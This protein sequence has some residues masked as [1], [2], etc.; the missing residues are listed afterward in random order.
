VAGIR[1]WAGRTVVVTG[2]LGFIGSHFVAELAARGA[3]VICLHRSRNVEMIRAL[4]ETD[5][6]RFMQLDLAESAA[7]DT[8][9]RRQGPRIDAVFHCAAMDGSSQFKI[10]N[11]A[12]I[13]E[14]NTRMNLNVL[15]AAHA[16]DVDTVVLLSSVEV[17]SM[18]SSGDHSDKPVL[19]SFPR[20]GYV[21]SKVFSELSAD[22]FR[23]QFGMNI[24][25]VRPTNVYGP[26]DS[27]GGADRVI[28]SMLRKAISGQEIEIWGNGTQTRDFIYVTDLVRATLQVAATDKYPTFDVGNGDSVSILELGRM[29]FAVLGL[30]ERIQLHPA[31]PTGV[32]GDP[33]DLSRLREVIDFTPLSLGEG[34][35]RM[36]S[37]Y[38]AE[39][40]AVD[41]PATDRPLAH[42]LRALAG[43]ISQPSQ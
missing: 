25:V 32:A 4:P 6:I 27:L 31:K 23:E 19:A 30:P 14:A 15:N 33:P 29:L 13:L 22:L 10:K 21:L 41:H 8:L 38:Q 20:G 3:E 9:F 2:G 36:I 42:H 26:R 12:E 43:V 34:L 28:P 11:S 40:Q 39:D 37:C 7:L 35:D 16:Y 24:I 5:R 18:I 17:R 1:E